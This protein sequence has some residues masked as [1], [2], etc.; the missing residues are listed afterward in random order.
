MLQGA[1]PPKNWQRPTVRQRDLRQVYRVVHAHKSKDSFSLFSLD[2]AEILPQLCAM[3]LTNLY[4]A[5]VY[6]VSFKIGRDK[7]DLSRHNS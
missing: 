7:L 3:L 2:Q 1:G 6:L 5:G 4:I